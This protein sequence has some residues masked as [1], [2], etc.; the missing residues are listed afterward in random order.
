MHPRDVGIKRWYRILTGYQRVTHGM[1]RHHLQ[2]LKPH[3]K[4]KKFRD[5]G[6]LFP[7]VNPNGSKLRRLA[8]RFD[9]K[10]QTHAYEA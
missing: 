6:G 8:Y 2:G 7:L 9:C 10:Q 3:E 1:G 4:P 5:R